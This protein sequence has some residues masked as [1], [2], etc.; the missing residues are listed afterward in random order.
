MS[1]ATQ[2]PKRGPRTIVKVVGSLTILVVL[3]GA[4]ELVAFGVGRYLEPRGVFYR[5]AEADGFESYIADRDPVLGW[6]APSVYGTDEY[7]ETG[8]LL[9]PAFADTRKACVSL[10]G[11]SFTWGG[12]VDPEHA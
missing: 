6:P 7:D 1:A 4:M 12:E 2:P 3:L 8:S 11:D 9:I 10:Y 5:P